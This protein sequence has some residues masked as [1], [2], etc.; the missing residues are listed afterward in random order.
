[1]AE[2]QVHKRHAQDRSL[3][4]VVGGSEGRRFDSSG[5]TDGD[6][7]GGRRVPDEDGDE[8]LRHEDCQALEGECEVDG[9]DRALVGRL[10]LHDRLELL[11]CK[12]WRDYGGRLEDGEEDAR[13]EDHLED[14]SLIIP[15]GRGVGRHVRGERL[16]LG[17]L[18]GDE[19]AHRNDDSEHKLD[20]ADAPNLLVAEAAEDPRVRVQVLNPDVYHAKEVSRGE[21]VADDHCRCVDSR[22]YAKDVDADEANEEE[23]EDEL[24][25]RLVLRA[26]HPTLSEEGAHRIVE[27]VRVD[28]VDER[29]DGWEA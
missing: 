11:P 19:R 22:K 3:G 18:A 15:L 29:W 26:G 23:A 7:V 1:L 21:G 24:D 17:I 5:R 4:I 13:A 27:L 25:D 28:L 16:V 14:E 20:D 12:V 8:R 2:A 10:L 6:A 9:G